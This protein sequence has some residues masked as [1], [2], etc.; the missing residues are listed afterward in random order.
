[1]SID[2]L[3]LKIATCEARI[4]VIGLGYVGLP[5]SLR[6]AEKGFSTYG[7]DIDKTKIEQ[8]KSGKSYINHIKKN[9][10]AK[11]IK[12]KFSVHNDF[13]KISSSDVIIICVPTPLDDFDKPDTSF[14]LKTL[15]FLGPHLKPNQILILE[16]TSFPGTTEEIL[17]PFIDSLNKSKKSNLLR[18]NSEMLNLGENFF[19]GYSPEREDPA[20]QDYQ[21]KDIPKVVSGWTQNCHNSITLR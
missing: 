13:K 4:S 6:F 7:I 17:V 5:L 12:S 15:K 16:S 18:G 10:I 20:N 1:M 9:D 2:R 19:L 21:T 8:I 3:K 14:I 11:A